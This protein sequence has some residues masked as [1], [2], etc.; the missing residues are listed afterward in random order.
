MKKIGLII[1][2]VLMVLAASSFCY[3]DRH[4]RGH[5]GH[6][7]WGVVIVPGPVYPYP[8]YPAYGPSP[9]CENRCYDRVVP[10]CRR[11]SWG[12]RWCHDKIVRECER[13]CY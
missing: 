12:D 4:G 1:C 11:D 7:G 2:I 9:V 10:V 3:A 6:S 5:G 13:V 8:Y